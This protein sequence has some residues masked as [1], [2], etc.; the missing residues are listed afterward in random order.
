M[1]MSVA[2]TRSW[3][4]HSIVML[5]TLLAMLV[6]SSSEFFSLV[7]WWGVTSK[8]GHSFVVFPLIGYLVY[9]RRVQLLR[10]L[11][12]PE[13]KAS[14]PLAVL[15]L[16]MAMST[17][18]N[19]GIL[20]ETA[21]VLMIPVL[22]WLIMGRK[23]A[24]ELLI[25]FCLI[26]TTAPIWEL[27]APLLTEITTDVSYF[28]LKIL[29]V[30]VFR[31]GG[32]LII[33]EGTFE[34]ADGCGGFRYFIVGLTLGLASAYLN[35]HKTSSRIIV[36]A[37]AVFLSMIGNWVRVMIV[38]WSGHVTNMQHQFVDEHVNLGWWVFV[39]V[40]FP[41][42]IAMS[43]F[44]TAEVVEPVSSG[45]EASNYSIRKLG[46]AFML[47]LGVM[48]VFPWAVN[49]LNS[50]ESPQTAVSNTKLLGA[51]EHW[52]GPYTYRGDWS[53]HFVGVE[54]QEI[55]SYEKDGRELSAYVAYYINQEQDKELVNFNHTVVSENW[56]SY[57]QENLSLALNEKSS[58]SVVQQ[59]VSTQR[60]KK[61]IWSWYYVAGI[62]TA[63]HRVA[64]ILEVGKMFG[65]EKVSAIIA[66]LSDGYNKQEPVDD[67]SLEF[68]SKIHPMVM[69]NL[70]SL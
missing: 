48:V 29:G 52:V 37:I 62:E 46:G 41:F 67:L 61:L 51:I 30:P 5:I 15:V 43:R 57:S 44:A 27:F 68:I 26:I 65:A 50:S 22:V 63:D 53:P 1:T 47:A 40:F 34:V 8:Y 13:L 31:E 49:N 17:F 69:R 55:Y 4:A 20:S 64:K 6:A 28:C 66:I 10:H 18:I 14:I 60:G 56:I 2:M 39:A 3:Y 70:Q 19:V 36:I 12:L 7:S 38:I 25:P 54:R 33:P 35:F 23:I 16:G 24:L 9:E 58:L 32:F 59:L 45:V 21:L 11:P 42:F